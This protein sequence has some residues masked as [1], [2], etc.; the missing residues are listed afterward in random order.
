[1]RLIW[2]WCITPLWWNI[3]GSITLDIYHRRLYVHFLCASVS[4][5]FRTR[6]ADFWLGGAKREMPP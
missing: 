6:T 2:N 4:V 1:M 5:E 3:P